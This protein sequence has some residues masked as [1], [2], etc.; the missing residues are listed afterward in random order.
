MA[1]TVSF[2]SHTLEVG[3]LLLPWDV[4]FTLSLFS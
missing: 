4:V 3:F 2:G 1:V